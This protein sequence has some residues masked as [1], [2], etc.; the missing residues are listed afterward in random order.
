MGAELGGRYERPGLSAA[1]TLWAVDLEVLNL[2]DRR[3]NDIIYFYT[4]RLSGEAAEGVDDYHLHPQ[5][6]RQFRFGIKVVM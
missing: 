2:F 6:P 4:S 5:K 1:V 3:D